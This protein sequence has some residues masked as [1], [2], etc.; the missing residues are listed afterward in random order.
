[1]LLI[2]GDNDELVSVTQSRKMATAMASAGLNHRLLEVRGGVHFGM[3]GPDPGDDAAYATAPDGSGQKCFI[4][5]AEMFSFLE[6]HGLLA[7]V[8]KTP[9]PF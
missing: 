1:M 9:I 2:H 4:R 8:N 7:G 3:N 6:E 5:E